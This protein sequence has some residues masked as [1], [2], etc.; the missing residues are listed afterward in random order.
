MI[1]TKVVWVQLTSYFG[2]KKYYAVPLRH[3]YPVKASTPAR[4][5]PGILLE[6]LK[7]CMSLQWLLYKSGGGELSG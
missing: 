6:A 5:H 2:A 7:G 4:I 3:S 1:T